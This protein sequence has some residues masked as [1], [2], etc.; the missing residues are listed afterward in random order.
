MT[1]FHETADLLV[2]PSLDEAIGLPILEKMAFAFPV[3]T[4]NISVTSNRRSMPET[5]ARRELAWSVGTAG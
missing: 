4:S 2:Y 3:V 1:L 5:G